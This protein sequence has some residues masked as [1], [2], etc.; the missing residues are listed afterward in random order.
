MPINLLLSPIYHH[1]TSVVALSLLCDGAIA[2]SL[3]TGM[4]LCSCCLC[5]SREAHHPGEVRASITTVPAGFQKA[6]EVHLPNPGKMDSLKCQNN[7][8]NDRSLELYQV[9]RKIR[10]SLA[11]QNGLVTEQS[12]HEEGLEVQLHDYRVRKHF[13]GAYQD[14]LMATRG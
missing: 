1:Q 11:S 5:W 14:L 3:K 2:V 9:W 8:A 6:S 13:K 7:A 10:L 4:L 12:H